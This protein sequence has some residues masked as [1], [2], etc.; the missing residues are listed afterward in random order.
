LP[1]P[2]ITPP[3]TKI[4]LVLTTFL[5]G[6]RFLFSIVFYDDFS[7]KSEKKSVDK[8]FFKKFSF[9]CAQDGKKYTS[10]FSWTTAPHPLF[11]LSI[12]SKK[13]RG[14]RG[15]E[16]VSQKNGEGAEG[17]RLNKAE[18]AGRYSK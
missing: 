18:A 2:D 17:V 13:W 16:A 11:P 7:I 10:L 4:Y 14:G 12:F 15:G 5:L 3:T 9:D 8:N 6:A 1:T